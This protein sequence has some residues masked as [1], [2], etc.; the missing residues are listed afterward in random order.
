MLPAVSCDEL[1][2]APFIQPEIMPIA[3]L[4][5]GQT[6]K[7]ANPLSDDERDERFT[8]VEL[9]GDRV[10]VEFICDMRVKPQSVSLAADLESIDEA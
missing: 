9:R 1:H 5:V 6:V 8:V 7:F 2:T 10:L 3:P 4:A